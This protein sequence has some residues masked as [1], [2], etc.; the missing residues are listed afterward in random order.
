M[1]DLNQTKA[2]IMQTNQIKSFIILA[3]ISPFEEMS[4][5]WR[6]VD[7]TVFDLTCPRFELQTSRSRD[8]RV[9]ARPTGRS[10]NYADYESQNK[11][12]LLH[13]VFLIAHSVY[14]V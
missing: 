7:N 12:T 9:T 3:L 10:T 1:S 8:E 11:K 2:H 6:A 4:Q 13:T 14:F 5:R